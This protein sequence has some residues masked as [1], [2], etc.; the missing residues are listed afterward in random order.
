MM[1]TSQLTFNPTFF[2]ENSSSIE[3]EDS[4]L[5]P[6]IS[7][8][9]DCPTCRLNQPD[10]SF[11]CLHI[12]SR[13][14]T[15]KTCEELLKQLHTSFH[16]VSMENVVL[17]SENEALRRAFKSK[18]EAVDILK[19]ST[20]KPFDID[21]TC[22]N[23]FHENLAL[24]SEVAQVKAN[25]A[26]VQ[27]ALTANQ[28]A[29][30]ARVKGLFETIT[31]L[32]ERLKKFHVRPDLSL[33]E[34]AYLTGTCQN[35]T[36]DCKQ[37]GISKS[38][39]VNV[40]TTLSSKMSSLSGC[41]D[42]PSPSALG[43]T[44]R[45]GRP[46]TNATD[47]TVAC[48]KH[49]GETVATQFTSSASVPNSLSSCVVAQADSH[50]SP[51]IVGSNTLLS[52]ID[53]KYTHCSCFPAEQSLCDCALASIIVQRNLLKCSHQLST[54]KRRVRDL[55]ITINAYKIALE[56]EFGRNQA[57][58]EAF[59]SVL[60]SVR[61]DISSVIPSTA[62]ET[63]RK[64]LKCADSTLFP[65]KQSSDPSVALNR[66]LLW[67]HK[68]MRQLVRRMQRWAAS[69]VQDI[70]TS[71][72]NSTWRT[73]PG[74]LDTLSSVPSRSRVH[75]SMDL[76]FLSNITPKPPTRLA[77]RRTSRGSQRQ[78]ERLRESRP[79]VEVSYWSD[80]NSTPDSSSSSRTMSPY[81]QPPKTKLDKCVYNY[82]DGA[83]LLARVRS[84]D[85]SACHTEE[86]T[87]SEQESNLQLLSHIILKLN[88]LHELVT[89]QRIMWK[90]ST[91]N[92]AN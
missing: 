91:S 70:T 62:S 68:T 34:N 67:F 36:G 76:S 6:P 50:C 25:L 14:S 28:N 27:G 49:E 83:R 26:I 46:T 73:N 22:W 58:V 87:A 7:S 54:K 12:N 35:L 41:L 19:S 39:P 60:S 43:S 13:S 57:M 17:R 65:E 38:P 10:S 88:E 74:P 40:I 3:S 84:L 32:K 86:A 53:A 81:R 52:R 66:L 15:A 20:S 89:K 59:S 2:R 85:L 37:L 21:Q 42:F 72:A 44:V 5:N 56:S 82:G 45:R 18:C 47:V 51:Q 30:E 9:L 23:A 69:S 48:H 77:R 24:T 92:E 1:E 90:L 11:I 31:H 29:Y 8:T 4:S 16:L 79:M 63:V 78:I 61:A 33:E 64:T 71:R 80:A 55:K 75:Q